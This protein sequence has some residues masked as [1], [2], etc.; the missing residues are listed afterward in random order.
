MDE[1]LVTIRDI[2]NWWYI[3]YTN[4]IIQ[5]TSKLLKIISDQTSLSLLLK[6]FFIPWHRDYSIM[7]YAMGITMRILYLPFS[8][9]IYAIV[10][11]LCYIYILIVYAL[12]ILIIILPI[13]LPIL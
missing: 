10:A 5:K 8:L 7:G 13:I 3:D 2:L 12:P 1:T 6:T 4:Q 9:F 11:T